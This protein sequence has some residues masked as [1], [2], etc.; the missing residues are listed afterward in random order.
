MGAVLPTG[1]LRLPSP[2]LARWQVQP[3]GT[4]KAWTETVLMRPGTGRAANTLEGHDRYLSGLLHQGVVIRDLISG[5]LRFDYATRRKAGEAAALALTE[6]LDRQ[7]VMMA[8][9]AGHRQRLRTVQG[10]AAIP[11]QLL[12][13]H[14]EVWLRFRWELLAPRD[15]AMADLMAAILRLYYL[16]A[17]MW[18]QGPG[19]HHLL[20]RIEARVPAPQARRKATLLLEVG[21]QLL[22]TSQGA[23]HSLHDTVSFRRGQLM[24]SMTSPPPASSPPSVTT[25]AGRLDMADRPLPR[26]PTPPGSRRPVPPRSAVST[27]GTTTASSWEPQAAPGSLPAVDAP[28][29]LHGYP[30]GQI[31]INLP[32]RSETHRRQTTLG[33]LGSSLFQ[34][35]FRQPARS[36]SGDEMEMER[37]VSSAPPPSPEDIRLLAEYSE[38]KEPTQAAGGKGQE[39]LVVTPDKNRLKKF[40]LIGQLEYWLPEIPLSCKAVWRKS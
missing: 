19:V 14:E 15:P 16:P 10:P 36:V 26:P 7:W 17:F 29:M 6:W 21:D 34:R 37:R 12:R 28:P 33:S 38:P 30:S 31:K 3:D 25:R 40:R 18:V 11:T 24:A 1:Y 8:D 5:N 20:N 35:L 2:I 27:S 23:A 13:E 32:E 22:T 39:K 9:L 4:R